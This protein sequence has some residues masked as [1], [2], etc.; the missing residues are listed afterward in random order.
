[1]V[2]LR[3][4]QMNG[5]VWFVANHPTVMSG[6]DVEDVTG[7]HLADAAVYHRKSRAPRN[8]DPDVL[9][10]AKLFTLRLADVLRPS[11]AR[12]IARAANRQAPNVYYFERALLEGEGF[13]GIFKSF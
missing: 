7:L 9:D 12:L 4:H 3:A 11:P 5:N 2:L 1:T 10:H 13:I 6:R 8:H